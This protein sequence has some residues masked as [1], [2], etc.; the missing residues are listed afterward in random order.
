MPAP[1]AH[2]SAAPL[3]PVPS[4]THGRQSP[5]REPRPI[6]PVILKVAESTKCS[7]DCTPSDTG[8]NEEGLSELVIAN[9]KGAY[10]NPWRISE[11]AAYRQLHVFCLLKHHAVNSTG[12]FCDL[13]SVHHDNN[14]DGFGRCVLPE[15]SWGRCVVSSLRLSAEAKLRQWEALPSLRHCPRVLSSQEFCC[16]VLS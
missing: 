5:A 6:A 14:P 15:I 11:W 12:E 16:A 7:I 1:S 3:S 9:G 8:P 13:L 10:I 4:F 2:H